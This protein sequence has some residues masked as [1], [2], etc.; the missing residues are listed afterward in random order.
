MNEQQHPLPEVLGA[1]FEGGLDGEERA[2][3]VVHLAGCDLCVGFMRGARVA[4]DDEA[5]TAGGT[6]VPF[7][8]RPWLV[9]AAAALIAVLGLAAGYAFLQARDR[10][11]VQTLIAAAPETYRTIEPRLTGF[12]WAE[13]R[14]LRAGEG[15]PVDAEGLRLAGAAG[16]VLS[17]TQN[18]ESAEARR[19]S[20]VA[21]L[22]VRETSRATAELRK[23]TARDPR[24]AAAWNDLAA[25]LY[26][27]AVQQRRHAALA[28]A[29]AAADRAA[30]LAPS[31]PEARFNRALILERMGLRAEAASAWRESL[32]ADPSSPWAAEARRRLG[33]LAA[34]PQARFR[35]RVATLETAAAAGD[36]GRVERDLRDLPQEVRG[37]FESD[38]LGRWGEAALRGDARGAETLLTAART[39]GV[40]LRKFSGETLLA[41]A[42]EAIDRARG[43]RRLQ[44]AGGHAAYRRGRLAYRDGDLPAAERELLAA[45]AALDAAGSP[46]SGMARVYAAAVVF[47]QNR[48][49]AAD[50]LLRP[51]VSH[52]VHTHFALRGQAAA[53]LG[54]CSSYAGRWSEA[55]AHRQAAVEA[56]RRAGEP[57]QVAD[58]E[59]AIGEVHSTTGDVDKAWAHRLAALRVL[60]DGTH[61]NR[62][63]AALATYA[64]GELRAGRREAA[65]ALLRLELAEAE[66]VGDPLLI[67]DTLKRRA[68]LHADDDL[69]AAMRDLRA[70]RASAARAADSGLRARF[71]A[72]CALVEGVVDRTRHPRRSA[73][74]LTAAVDFARTWGD[75]R[76]LPEALL[77]RARTH[78]AAGRDDEA[79]ADLAAAIEEVDERRMAENGGGSMF[80]AAEA[81]FDEA[82]DLLLTRGENDRAFVYAER[83]NAR[84]MFDPTTSTT[85][86][87]AA[88]QL[89]P[90]TI[91]VQFAL[92]P[93]SVAAFTLTRD[94]L[95]VVRQTADRAAV[96]SD[97]RTLREWI[98]S[99]R[100]METIRPLA[101]RLHALLIAPLA[102]D[103]RTSSLV[104]AGGRV[105]QSVPWAVLWDAERRAHLV[106]RTDITVAP[107]FGAWRHHR[108][109]LASMA[110]D[111]RLLLVTSDLRPQLDPLTD[112][113]RE[114][115]AIE[116]VYPRHETLTDA[117]ATPSRFLAAAAASD[118]VHYAG[119]ARAAALLLG[120]DELAATDIARARLTRT[121]LVVLAACNTLGDESARLEGSPSLAR[122]FLTAG[123]PTV[124]GTLWPIDDAHAATLFTALHRRLRAGSTVPAALREAQ[125]AMLRGGNAELAHPVAW[126]A[127]EVLGAAQ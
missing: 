47:D 27:D 94:G 26:T 89:P 103:G 74:R 110:A 111:E 106:E 14:H 56:F 13:L 51:V 112:L 120:D 59:I 6:V 60:G 44:A 1:F 46:M 92:L 73:A 63:L 3:V 24:N 29:L 115:A 97:V 49:G 65:G 28:D 22:L 15:S 70:A 99:R 2:A 98:E 78:R 40:A 119:H 96:E 21:S 36:V 90:G 17:Q 124:V 43:E 127:A 122:A 61:G 105:L 8:R 50:A 33:A 23:A 76:L 126:A 100:R 75:R 64:R 91:L 55:L 86:P 20:G 123:V 42:V 101:A 71:E 7:R 35:D 58:S 16:E 108:A 18:D 116:A 80:D 19:A 82:V 114:I 85:G 104:I 107:G 11:G 83:A 10:T 125:L 121:R 12:R 84:A 95:R 102:L 67:A 93:R 62:L 88:S 34:K 57:A 81:L 109:R 69:D 39:A 52:S 32:A 87:I 4:R 54:R 25:A 48:I 45:A 68:R 31:M 72:E 77:E 38:V 113:R 9:A 66:R 53:L 79:W 30:D 5:R 118:I 117:A 37:W 41:V